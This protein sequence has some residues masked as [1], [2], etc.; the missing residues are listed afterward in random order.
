M[1]NARTSHAAPSRFFCALCTDQILGEQPHREPLG[2]NGAMVNVCD[3][4]HTEPAREKRGPERA[5]DGAGPSLSREAVSTGARK[6][7]GA[8]RYQDKL[9]AAVRRGITPSLPRDQGDI[10]MEQHIHEGK[11]RVRA[12]STNTIAKA[13]RNAAR[14]DR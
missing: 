6:V 13:R 12:G 4:C 1:S 8:K 9:E 2:R 3:S 5:Y 14:T 7:M 10:V 11:R